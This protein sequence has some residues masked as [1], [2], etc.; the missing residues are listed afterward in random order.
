MNATVENSAAFLAMNE[1]MVDQNQD[2]TKGYTYDT[3]RY[4][5]RTER[6]GFFSSLFRGLGSLIPFVGNKVRAKQTGVEN[7]AFFAQVVERQAGEERVVR[8]YCDH[9]PNRSELYGWEWMANEEWR[10]QALVLCAMLPVR[11]AQFIPLD[12]SGNWE[13][14]A[15]STVAT[16]VVANLALDQEY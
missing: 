4:P 15:I 9:T 2:F 10:R 12:A 7:V 16:P 6:R 8:L 1:K 11:D 3:S 13:F 5:K 14:L